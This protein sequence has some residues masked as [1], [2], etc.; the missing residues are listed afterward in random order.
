MWTKIATFK[1]NS[2]Q[3]RE[4]YII[5]YFYTEFRGNMEA[6]YLNKIVFK[7][8]ISG[9]ITRLLLK[10]HQYKVRI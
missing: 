8:K 6:C 9:D 3:E 7:N 4:T 1:D 2:V 5:S 10:Y